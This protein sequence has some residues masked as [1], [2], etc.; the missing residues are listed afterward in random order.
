[1]KVKRHPILGFFSGLVLG[2]GV[3]LILFTLGVVPLTVAWLAGLTIAGV[4]LGVAWAYAAPARGRK[5]AAS[6][7]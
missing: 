7:G 4:V 1:M 3:A 2:L 5:A 6:S